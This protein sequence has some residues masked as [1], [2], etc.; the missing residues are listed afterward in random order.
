MEIQNGMPEKC[1]EALSP[2][3]IPCLLHLFHLAVP[4]LSIPK[5]QLSAEQPSMKKTGT[6][7]KTSSTAKDIKKEPLRGR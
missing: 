3:H 4:E 1:M 6:Y 5:S 7:Q 2:F